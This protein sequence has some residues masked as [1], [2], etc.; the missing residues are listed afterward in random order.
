MKCLTCK[1]VGC[2]G[3]MQ[4]MCLACKGTGETHVTN[5]DRVAASPEKLAEF[6]SKATC[7]CWDCNRIYAAI[8][9]HYNSG[10]TCFC[11]KET[12]LAWL[13]QEAAE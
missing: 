10:M 7:E 8:C 6:I 12:A 5:F 9:P 13:E 11:S 4:E 1:G 3:P 2:V